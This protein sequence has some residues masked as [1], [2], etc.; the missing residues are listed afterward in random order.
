MTQFEIS[1]AATQLFE[2][3]VFYARVG[4]RAYKAFAASG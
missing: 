3:G 4:T 2:G 1:V